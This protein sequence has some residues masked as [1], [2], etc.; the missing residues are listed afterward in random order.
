MWLYS[1]SHGHSAHHIARQS[2]AKSNQPSPTSFLVRQE[3]C[4]C[5]CTCSLSL[6]ACTCCTSELC[7]DYISESIQC[8]MRNPLQNEHYRNPHYRIVAIAL[9][10]QHY[11][12]RW[13]STTATGH[14]YYRMY[15]RNHAERP[16]A[17]LQASLQP[18]QTWTTV[19]LQERLQAPHYRFFVHYSVP[20][21]D[22]SFSEVEHYRQ[23]YRDCNFALQHWGFYALQPPYRLIPVVML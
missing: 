9:Q 8:K 17:T 1:P 7:H 12:S 18:C 19:T 10:M 2:S 22:Y 20:P 21:K 6:F 14:L 23:H 15:Y 5:L 3:F 13:S 4:F 16:A 11:R